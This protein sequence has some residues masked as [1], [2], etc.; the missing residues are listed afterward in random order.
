MSYIL[1]QGLTKTM[2]D[3]LNVG[4]GKPVVRQRLCITFIK[5]Y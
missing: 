2:T 3:W 4:W 1:T 5:I